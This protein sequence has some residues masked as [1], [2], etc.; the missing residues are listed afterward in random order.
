MVI[1]VLRKTKLV[2]ISGVAAVAVAGAGIGVAE[3]ADT[4]TPAPPPST[5]PSAPAHHTRHPGMLSRVAHG[6]FT[7]NGKQHRIVDI[8]RGTVQSVNANSVTVR[9]SDGFTASYALDGNTKVRKNKQ[10]SNTGQLAV[11][12]RVTVLAGVN[13]STAT[14]TH[15]ADSGPAPATHS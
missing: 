2:L 4:P 7:L 9:S 1:T 14:A 12:D 3:A 11:N 13:G 5:T 15:I 6:Q 10:Q 8:Q